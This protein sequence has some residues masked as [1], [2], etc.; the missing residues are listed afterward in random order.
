[1]R[2]PMK[3]RSGPRESLAAGESK[4]NGETP[5]LWG[6]QHSLAGLGYRW[7]RVLCHLL[8]LGCECGP[9]VARMVT[10]AAKMTG[11]TSGELTSAAPTFI[12]AARRPLSADV[13]VD[14]IPTIVAAMVM[15]M[16]P[17][18]AMT[19]A[20]TMDLDYIGRFGIVDGGALTG[21]R[22]CSLRDCKKHRS[23]DAD[24]SESFIHR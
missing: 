18:V 8:W 20:A 9:S 16:A 15:M 12:G 24:S 1:M 6:V 4:A 21:K 13:N 7:R 23:G 14:A 11:C 2:Q 3:F 17:P 19:P 22:T 5:T 10:A